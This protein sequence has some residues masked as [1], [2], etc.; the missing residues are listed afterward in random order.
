MPD[1]S[2]GEA[3]LIRHREGEDA[4]DR[5]SAESLCRARNL[6]GVH[7][8]SLARTAGNDRLGAHPARLRAGAQLGA[9]RV[10]GDDRANRSP[11][12][13]NQVAD[14]VAIDYQSGNLAEAGA[15]TPVI[16]PHQVADL[17]AISS[18]S[19]NL[20]ALV[21]AS[22]ARCHRGEPRKG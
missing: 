6:G 9:A 10:L 16:R 1:G 18:R 20:A 14:L 2:S 4:E 17:V 22:P 21:E 7:A 3:G 8:S 11:S 19:G 12:G 15:Q 13:R 5:G